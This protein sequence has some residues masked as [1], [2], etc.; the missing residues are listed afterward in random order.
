[1]STLQLLSSFETHEKLSRRKIGLNLTVCNN[2]T[3]KNA[4]TEDINEN[5]HENLEKRDQNIHQ[6]FKCEP[7]GKTFQN[8]STFSVHLSMIHNRLN[9]ELCGRKCRSWSSLVQHK[10]FQ[11]GISS[12]EFRCE[13]CTYACQSIRKLKNHIANKHSDQNNAHCKI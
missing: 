11:H 5:E 9:C 10:Y 2:E 13:F 4:K 8:E 7:C 6:I 12:S 3:P 1:M